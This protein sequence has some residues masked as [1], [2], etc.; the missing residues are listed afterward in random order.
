MQG[1]T[2]HQQ[3]QLDQA[4]TIYEQVLNLQPAHF[5]ALHLLGVIEHQRKHPQKSIDLIT[6]A[7]AIKPHDPGAQCNLGLPLALLGRDEEA[8]VCF[9]R[10]IALQP[11]FVEG[12]YNRGNALMRL[13]RT[14][15]AVTSFERAIALQP[16][17][18]K[19]H[20]NLGTALLALHRQ[21]ASITEFENAIAIWPD[22]AEAY[23]NRGDALQALERYEEALSSYDRAIALKPDYVEA[24][25]NRGNALFC[26]DRLDE[27]LASFDIAIS[28]RPDYA[29]AHYNQGNAFLKTGQHA[30]AIAC[31]D[32]A[33][34]F[35][36]EYPEASYNQGTAYLELGQHTKAL[37]CFDQA[38]KFRRNYA[39]AH[40]NQGKAYLQLRW[41]E[42][43]LRSFDLA[44]KY[45]PEHSESHCSKGDA[46]R[47]LGRPELA[48][49]SY[50]LAIQ[51]SPLNAVAHSNLGNALNDLGSSEQALQSFDHAIKLDP[52]FA[53]AH[54][55]RGSVLLSLGFTDQ[56]LCSYMKAVDLDPNHTQANSGLSSIRL[57]AKEWAT[58][59]GAYSHRKHINEAQ[60]IAWLD[61]VPVWQ[62][63]S[64]PGR[65]LM[66]AEQGIGDEVFLSK[67][68]D[69]FAK[70]YGEPTCIAVDPRLIPVFERSFPNLNFV[71]LT[72]LGQQD[73]QNFDVQIAMGDA[74]ALLAM[75]PLQ[76][77]QI[78][79]P[80]LLA[81][82]RPLDSGGQLKALKTRPR[83]GLSWK[84]KNAK[85]GA[86]KSMSLTQMMTTLKDLE[87]EWINLQ[88]GDVR[89]EIE[90]VKA[91]LGVQIHPINA[92]DIDHDLDAWLS[93]IKACDAVVTTSNSTAH[94]AGAIGKPG[95]VMVPFGKG[96]LWYWHREDG[97][98]P[99]YPSL[100]VTHAKAPNMW[101]ETLLAARSW[102][103]EGVLTVAA[104]LPDFLN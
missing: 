87:V 47:D 65:V 63:E 71:S 21:E 11:A 39:E 41:P 19:S 7:L 104:P 100:T 96:K 64:Q 101:D 16:L 51:L 13:Q 67:C 84:S 35:R 76:H 1:L 34:R 24:Y 25:S 2:L 55:N 86:E 8:L 36:P 31:F 3:G 80:H 20:Y 48:L 33:I 18:A 15:E 38:I 9:E 93:L 88:Y 45:R 30:K 17:H 83:I 75:N 23:S 66:L 52:N 78:A 61:K 73:P 103:T 68:L 85:F 74:A 22:Y 6:R 94:F 32:Q 44:V 98:S 46:L 81:D 10:A 90:H 27:S 62:N 92:V 5:D 14:Q 54:A 49:G 72:T 79:R 29:E 26:L 53:T 50:K 77:P 102:L 91:T 89:E 12:H 43:A 37:A 56:A 95:F 40:Y 28:L 82:R 4:R 59:W 99:W 97:P 60:P 58:G 69:L 42:K 57:T 70:Q